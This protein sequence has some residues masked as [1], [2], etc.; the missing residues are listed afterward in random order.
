MASLTWP[1]SNTRTLQP[2]TLQDGQGAVTTAV[3]L[4]NATNIQLKVARQNYPQ[5]TYTALTGTYTITSA[6]NGQFSWKFSAAD[7]ATPGVYNMVIIVTYA[8]GDIWSAGPF[9]F[10]IQETA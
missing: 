6:V 4:T 2:F 8:G 3:D 1:Q 9:A 7:V 5:T 10:T